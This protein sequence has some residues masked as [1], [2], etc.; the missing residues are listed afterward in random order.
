MSS[1]SK[2]II[3][4]IIFQ[5]YNLSAISVTSAT[6]GDIETPK[7]ATVGANT[8]NISSNAAG[9]RY[10]FNFSIEADKSYD[11]QLAGEINPKFDLFFFDISYY[12]L[13][14]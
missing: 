2:V 1:K 8:G 11:F 7:I 3:L 10:F 5:V 9:G 4:F 6:I 12:H 13:S 14:L